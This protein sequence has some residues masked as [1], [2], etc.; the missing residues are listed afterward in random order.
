[1]LTSEPKELT[2]LSRVFLEPANS[3]HRQYEALR[4]FF[5]D[6]LPSAEVAALFGYSPGSFRVLVHQ[7]RSQPDRDFFAPASRQGRPPGKRKQ[8][9]QQVIALRKQNLSVH[10]ISRALARD[11]QTLS[12]AAVAAILKEEGFAKLP[13]RAVAT[14]RQQGLT[15]LASD[16][17]EFDR[18]PGL[19]RYAPV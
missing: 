10:D 11:G 18:V 17:A 9:R 1:M 4:A 13:R 3:T 15:K 7:F 5:V 16:D 2:D 8:T 19:T 6:R 14:M 12:P